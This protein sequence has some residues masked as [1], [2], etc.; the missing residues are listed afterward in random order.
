MKIY[1]IDNEIGFPGQQELGS[2]GHDVAAQTD[3]TIEPRS[4]GIIPLNVVV[5]Y[6]RV[7]GNPVLLHT[8]LLF[9]YLFPFYPLI[10]SSIH[11][12]KSS[13]QCFLLIT[14]I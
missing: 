3:I 14:Y 9:A 13:L 2:Q 1:I 8:P 5:D 10:Y 4:S 11:L 12:F 6:S 7:E